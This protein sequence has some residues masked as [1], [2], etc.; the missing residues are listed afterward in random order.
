MRTLLTAF[1]LLLYL[2]AALA[3]QDSPSPSI[4]T[5]TAYLKKHWQ[6]P[7]DYLVQKFKTHDIVFVG[8]SHWIKH[9]PLFI[10]DLIPHLY[11]AGVYDLGIEFGSYELQDKVDR[12][13]MAGTYDEDLA[14]WLMFK[15]MVDWGYIEYMDLYRA[16][17]RLNRSLPKGAKRFRIINLGY[18]PDWRFRQKE[19][20]PELW[21]KVWHK[22]DPDEYMAKVIISEFVAKGRKAL[23]YMGK[24]HAFTRFKQ[25]V[26]DVPTKTLYRFE[27]RRTGNL[28][29]ER[30]PA[31]VFNVVLHSPFPALSG[32]GQRV[33]PV[34][35]VLD[36]LMGEFKDTRVGF[37]VVGTPFGDLRDSRTFYSYGYADFKL[38]DFCDGYVFQK[39]LAKYEAVTIDESF[40]TESNLAEAI[41]RLASPEARDRFKRPEDFL[42]T[43]RDPL[44]VVATYADVR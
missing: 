11:K 37:D 33:L 3:A 41:S 35:G 44:K 12:L 16:A 5:L 25:P 38:G 24:H 28:V 17:W 14:R 1:V 15:N 23:V 29:Y 40:V 26:Y 30:I 22:G 9:D 20:T 32:Y 7:E 19:M 34:H 6:R 42:K 18:T 39:P 13:I 43:M 31:R 21:K 27:D 4:Q 36:R 8:E 10:Q 2:S